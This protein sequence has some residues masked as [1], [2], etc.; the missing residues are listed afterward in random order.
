M[1]I[2]I[3]TTSNV[4]FDIYGTIYNS[5]YWE[6][7]LLLIKKM[8]SNISINYKGSIEK[9]KVQKL[10]QDYHFM[11]MPTTGENFGHVI[12][13]ALASGCPVIISDQTPWKDL[14]K[15]Q[16]GWDL[17]LEDTVHFVKIIEYCV[18]M[19]QNQYNTLSNEA[20]NFAREFIP[21]TQDTAVNQNRKL[22][23]L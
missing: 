10:F 3:K 22:F 23:K 12:F 4:V 1:E 9:N 18:G 13:E 7:C 2:L 5:K 8:P 17:S 16:I 6:E 11:F 21:G 19:Q 14:E 15:K 20:H